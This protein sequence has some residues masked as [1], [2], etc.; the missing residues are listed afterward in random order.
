MGYVLNMDDGYG[1]NF[2]QVY[3]GK[4]YPN[5]LMYTVG[6]LQTGY[7]Y[8]FTLQAINFNGLSSESLPVKFT[9]CIAPNL[10]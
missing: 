2:R 9:V 8:T 10:L 7:S 3:N 6:G 5:V 1:S 4:Y